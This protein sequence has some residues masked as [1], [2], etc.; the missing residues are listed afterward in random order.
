MN[1]TITALGALGLLGSFAI[2]GSV[3]VDPITPAP[4]ASADGFAQARR[5]ISNPTLF[6]LALPGTNLHPIFLYHN[7][8]DQITLANNGG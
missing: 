6:D 5:P 2:A 3:A 8:P 1:P 7:L 4:T